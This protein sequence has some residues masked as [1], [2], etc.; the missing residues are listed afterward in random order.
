MSTKQLLQRGYRSWEDFFFDLMIK[1]R[2]GPEGPQDLYMEL[3][4]V[5]RR[6]CIAFLADKT[7][8]KD[9]D[10]LEALKQIAIIL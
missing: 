6:S 3:K 1:S 2:S 10:A 5:E 4:T 7:A 9:P 8:E